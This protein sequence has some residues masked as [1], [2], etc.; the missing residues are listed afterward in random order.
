MKRTQQW[1]S[2]FNNATPFNT[3]KILIKFLWLAHNSCVNAYV[4]AY[5][6]YNV[7]LYIIFTL[8]VIIYFIYIHSFDTSVPGFIFSDQYI[9]ITTR[10]ASEHL[11][12]FGEHNHRQLKHDMNWKKWSIFTRDVAP[13]V[14]LVNEFSD[15]E[16][17]K[18]WILEPLIHVLKIVW[19]L[20]YAVHVRYH[21]DTTLMPLY[22]IMTHL[23]FYTTKLP[24]KELAFLYMVYCTRGSLLFWL[25]LLRNL[26][27][28]IRAV[29]NF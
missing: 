15:A 20:S 8:W 24:H 5:I 12:G 26:F 18:Y 11:Y 23:V 27:K 14:S 2:G 25:E 3:S 17:S 29:S 22:F 21:S 13:V 16:N 6:L 28:S 19:I 9:Q 1:V 4:H 7:N 10:L